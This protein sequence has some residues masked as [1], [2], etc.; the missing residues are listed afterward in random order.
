[1]KG[2]QCAV[3]RTSLDGTGPYLPDQAFTVKEA[4]DSYTS[5]SAIASFEEHSKGLIKDG[6]LADFVIL[7]HNPFDINE[8]RMH[9]IQ[10]LATYL[11][12][13]CVY[14]K[15]KADVQKLLYKPASRIVTT[16]R[17]NILC[18]LL[19]YCFESTNSMFCDRI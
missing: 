12:G 7:D 19:N 1:M 13:K 6:Y 16:A 3:T 5:K 9:T 11:N 14:I 10:V 17:S 2:I 18:I 8:N 15:E 4:I